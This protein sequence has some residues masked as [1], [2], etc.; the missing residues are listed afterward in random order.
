[1]PSLSDAKLS[2]QISGLEM[3]EMM[4]MLGMARIRA[5]RQIW[6]EVWKLNLC[7]VEKETR[8]H[9]RKG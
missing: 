5:K 9:L 1:M 3:M 4:E 8:K 7:G 2:A 6:F